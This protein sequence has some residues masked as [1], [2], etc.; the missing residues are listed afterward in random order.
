MHCTTPSIDRGAGPLSGALI[1]M[2]WWMKVIRNLESHQGKKER[3]HVV[4]W[5]MAVRCTCVWL[6]L[7]GA[8]T[9]PL[10]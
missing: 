3:G 6:P 10:T 1:E 8:P 4:M 5:I 2:A 7:G 9:D